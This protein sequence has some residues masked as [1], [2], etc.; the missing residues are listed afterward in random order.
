MF[1]V[2]EGQKIVSIYKMGNMVTLECGDVQG[3]IGFSEQCGLGGR[4]TNGILVSPGLI[5]RQR[6]EIGLG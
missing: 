3:A 5:G 1:C 2:E 6:D 4:G